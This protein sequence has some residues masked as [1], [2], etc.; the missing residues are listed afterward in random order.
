MTTYKH[1]YLML[2]NNLVDNNDHTKQLR[3]SLSNITTN[4]TR[5]LTIPNG[6]TTLVGTDLV[7]TITNKTIQGSTNV[8]DAN[9]LRSTTTTVNVSSSTAP[10][11]G[12]ILTATSSTTATWQDPKPTTY[13]NDSGTVTNPSLSSLKQWYGRVTTSTGTATFDLTVNGAGGTAIFSN[14]ASCYI[15]TSCSKNTTS[16]TAIPFSSVRSLDPS[17]KTI[18]VNVLTG[19]TGSILIGGTYTG[20]QVNASSCDVY[21]HVIGL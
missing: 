5:T 10:S 14:L 1:G 21:L 15:F 12:Q 4:T 19:N 7:Q 6:N 18:I 17:N 13:F 3:I 2:T 8:V 16:V 11:S 9:N 20:M